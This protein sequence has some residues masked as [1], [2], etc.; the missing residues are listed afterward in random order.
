MM[1]HESLRMAWAVCQFK[2]RKRAEGV[3]S[4]AVPSDVRF[5]AVVHVV[6]FLPCGCFCLP[7]RR[8]CVTVPPF[9]AR[10]LAKDMANGVLVTGPRSAGERPRRP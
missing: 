9:G 1:I 8:H 6:N 3:H 4:T 10:R 7:R 2:P 5:A